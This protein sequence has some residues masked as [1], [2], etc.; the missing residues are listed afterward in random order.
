MPDAALIHY[1]TDYVFSG[2]VQRPYR[3]D[4]GAGS[5]GYLREHKLAGEKA[6]AEVDVP[7]L[8]LRTSWVFGIG[9]K[10]FFNTIIRLAREREEVRAVDDQ[11][12]TPNWSKAV[13]EATA[14]I[15]MICGTRRTRPRRCDREG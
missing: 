4:D 13:A 1:S 10:G 5:D 7:H 2:S 6:I 8:I 15:L 12:G 3:E 9:G 11:I 14:R